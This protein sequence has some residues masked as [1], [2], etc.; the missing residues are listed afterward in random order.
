NWS[1]TDIIVKSL[2]KEIVDDAEILNV[3]MLGSDEKINWELT[4]QGLR[5]SFPK[6]KPCNYAYTFKISFDKQV[7]EQLKSEAVNVIMKHGG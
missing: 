2:N 4:D 5:L 6:E 3:Y 7:G 1:D